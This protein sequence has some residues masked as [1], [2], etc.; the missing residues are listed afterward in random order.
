M[1]WDLMAQKI[2]VA[3]NEAQSVS[4]L[5]VPI[6]IDPK[7]ASKIAATVVRDDVEAY[8]A[9]IPRVPTNKYDVLMTLGSFA[10]IGGLGT[11]F[12][13]L[14]LKLSDAPEY[15]STPTAKKTEEKTE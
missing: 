6:G 2:E 9:S 11:G 10:L 14:M 15:T 3:L 1:N 4:F 12:L 5:G 8:V 7:I 13:Y